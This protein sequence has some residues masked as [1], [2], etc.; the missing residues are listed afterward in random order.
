MAVAMAVQFYTFNE[1]FAELTAVLAGVL[2]IG[3]AVAGRAAWRKAARL[4]GLTAI[5]YAGAVAAAAPYLIYSLSH[6][7]GAVLTRQESAYSLQFARLI[8]PTSELMF[9]I[10]PLIA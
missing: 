2:V 9:G 5:A 6:Y 7:Q 3:V 8:V 10:T 4:A 1:G